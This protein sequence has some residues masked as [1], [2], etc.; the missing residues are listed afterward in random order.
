MFVMCREQFSSHRKCCIFVSYSLIRTGILEEVA[1]EL[2]LE[3]CIEILTLKMWNKQKKQEGKCTGEEKQ[4]TSG[5]SQLQTGLQR[6][7]VSAS[8][9]RMVW[10]LGVLNTGRRLALNAV[11]KGSHRWPAVLS[12]SNPQHCRAVNE[13]FSYTVQ[14]ELQS[15]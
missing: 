14:G 15:H 1:S 6:P 11:K 4:C 3:F 8:I 2:V 5:N 7:I 12:H 13:Y 9:G 10:P